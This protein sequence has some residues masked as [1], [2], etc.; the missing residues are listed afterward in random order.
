MKMSRK[1]GYKVLN[2]KGTDLSS[3]SFTLDGIYDSIEGN[4]N[5]ALLLT[6][7]VID[8]VEKADVFVTAEVDSDANYVIKAYDKTI[9]IA[10]DDTVTVADGGNHL[11]AYEVY[12]SDLQGTLLLPLKIEDIS[13]SV[14]DSLSDLTDTEKDQII[15][16]YNYCVNNNLVTSKSYIVGIK[17]NLLSWTSPTIEIYYNSTS[18]NIIFTAFVSSDYE[19]ATYTFTVEDNEV[20]ALQIEDNTF[21]D[22]LSI[23]YIAQLL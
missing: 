9:T 11:Y 3:A 15:K 18:L 13:I 7:I 21:A 4:Y 22:G 10:S 16:L 5:K 20:T 23:K 19:T 14:G 12:D 6:G 8:S 17:S 2:L 1:A